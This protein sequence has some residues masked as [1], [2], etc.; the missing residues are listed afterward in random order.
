MNPLSICRRCLCGACTMHKCPY[1][2]SKLVELCYM[3]CFQDGRLIPRLDCDYFCN[4]HKI[5]V[6]RFKNRGTTRKLYTSNDVTDMLSAI[7]DKLGGDM[8]DVNLGRY[9]VIVN[10]GQLVKTFDNHKQAEEF[11]RN[12]KNQKVQIKKL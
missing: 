7:L 1:N 5:K 8:S 2:R 11:A 9:Q 4:K 6:Y 12:F 10:N 3:S